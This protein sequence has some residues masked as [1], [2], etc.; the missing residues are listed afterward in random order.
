VTL[1]KGEIAVTHDNLIGS[2]V[3][4]RR[5]LSN[6]ITNA[7]KYN[8]TDGRVNISCRE[9]NR[10]TEDGKI[11]FDIVC[12]DTGIGM[13]RDFQKHMFEQFTQENAVGELSHHG[14]G[15][16]LPIVKSLVDKMG[17]TVTCKSKRGEGTTFYISIPFA[18]DDTKTAGETNSAKIK[19]SVNDTAA[20]TAEDN[21]AADNKTPSDESLTGIKILV[22]EDNDL[23]MEIAEFMLEDAG[24]IVTEAWNGQEAVE[25]FSAAEPGTFDMILMDMMMPVM[26]GLEATRAIRALP[27][28]DAATIPIVAMTANV[29]EEDVNATKEAG[30]NAHLAKPIDE[31]QL[32]DT[33]LEQTGKQS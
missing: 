16:G 12:S 14:T 9:T 5:V 6:I 23:N 31:K 29:F 15:L 19:D 30:M 18:V 25:K 27:R 22:V 24:I 20:G 17:G 8:R 2:T 21:D 3:H 7:I 10:T 26:D 1:E 13:S 4:I 33:I 28:D 11:F 32:R